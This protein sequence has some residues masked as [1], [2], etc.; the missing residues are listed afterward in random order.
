LEF[1]QKSF[2]SLQNKPG[3]LMFS[4]HIT[5]PV[6]N[7]NSGGLLLLYFRCEVINKISVATFEMNTLI[8]VPQLFLQLLNE[9]NSLSPF[10]TN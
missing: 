4:L 10:Y 6:P 7:G 3:N 2:E 8:F 5:G 1:L 9:T